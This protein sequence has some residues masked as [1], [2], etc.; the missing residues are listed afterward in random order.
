MGEAPCSVQAS[1]TRMA[2]AD[3]KKMG[4]QDLGCGCKASDSNPDI[5]TKV[6]QVSGKV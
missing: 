1:E 2:R 5:R 6:K 4:T 3:L